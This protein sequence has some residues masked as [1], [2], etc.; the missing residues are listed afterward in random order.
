MMSVEEGWV[1]KMEQRCF[2]KGLGMAWAVVVNVPL[3]VIR[4]VW[5]SQGTG[6][7]RDGLD[8]STVIC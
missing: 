1:R 5:G 8:G 4:V 6:E 3:G 7:G 2:V